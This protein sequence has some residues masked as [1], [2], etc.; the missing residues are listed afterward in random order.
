[1]LRVGTDCSGI[2]A[3][4]QALLQLKIPFKHCF[5]SDIDKYAIQ[6]IK[7]NYKPEIIFG[8]S[9]GKYPDG[10]ITKRKISTVPHIDLYVCGFPCQ[11]FSSAGKR[12][13]FKDIRGQVFWSC[14]DVI[15]RKKPTYFILENVKGLLFH[16]KEAPKDKYGKT[17]KVIWAE[18]EKL[19]RF[20]YYVDW[21]VL[22]TRHYGIPQNRERVFF[23]GTKR[24]EFSW[25]K[26]IKMKKL[27]KYVDW[28]DTEKRKIP[29]CA[30]EL[31]KNMKKD[32]KKKIFID[33]GF[34]KN[35]FVNADLY[36]GAITANC[37]KNWCIPLQRHANM[38]ELLSLQGFPKN[39]KQEVS[40]TQMKKQIGN[41]MSV[42]VLKEIIKQILD[43]KTKNISKRYI[44]KYLGKTLDTSQ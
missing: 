24:G 30:I 38:K 13:G 34:R 18:I 25:P 21:K 28:K 35:K 32:M 37:V 12:E 22:N 29:N 19:K 43:Y 8:D 20:G 23:V 4:I 27:E 5:S 39:F 10:D 6:S 36:I 15:K 42:N 1:M 16:N 14:L 33:L 40:N 44:I 11:T 31:I 26:P 9:D 41:S 17:F 3:P 2:E 7:A